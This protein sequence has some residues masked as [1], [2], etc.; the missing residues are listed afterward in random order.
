MDKQQL[1]DRLI[2]LR[3]NLDHIIDELRKDISTPGSTRTQLE[4]VRMQIQDSVSMTNADAPSRTSSLPTP[5]SGSRFLDVL[6]LS[7]D[8]QSVY[9]AILKRDVHH[10]IDDVDDRAQALRRSR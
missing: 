6:D 8:L 2:V 7:D 9:V 10:P 1:L 4:S 5:S 3:S